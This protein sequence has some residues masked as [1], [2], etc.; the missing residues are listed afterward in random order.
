MPSPKKFELHISDESINFLVT[1]LSSA[2]LPAT[3]PDGWTEEQG[4]P[5]DQM[6]HM[7]SYWLNSYLPRWRERE[8]ALN[9]LPM[10]T[11]PINAGEFGTLNIHFLWK[12]AKEPNSVPLL[13]VHG[14]PGCFLEGTKLLD[15]LTEGEN[16]S[17]VFDV[18]VPSLPNYGFSDGV[19]KV[20]ECTSLVNIDCPRKKG[21]HLGQYATVLHNLMISLGYKEYVIQG[22]D[23]GSIISRTQARLF[24]ESVR[25]VHV[26]MVAIRPANLLW[27]P[28]TLLK[29][30]TVPWTADEKR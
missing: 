2:R 10:Y 6:T 12:K 20:S 3:F 19:Q 11:L 15:P 25:A 21:F 26:N 27:S 16:G 30:L 5:R 7:L 29:F 13:F 24:P 1:K 4:V 9:G 18:I 14:W 17:V 22:G 8:A 23:W 28:L